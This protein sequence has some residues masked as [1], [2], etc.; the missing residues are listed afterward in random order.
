MIE[1]VLIQTQIKNE[2]IKLDLKGLN[3]GMVITYDK[4][5]AGK[6]EEK[7]SYSSETERRKNLPKFDIAISNTQPSDFFMKPTFIG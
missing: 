3:K 6:K 1:N 4:K 5:Q 7:K 2:T